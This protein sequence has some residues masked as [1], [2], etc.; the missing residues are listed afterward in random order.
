MGWNGFIPHVIITEFI[1]LVKIQRNSKM[2]K[3]PVKKIICEKSYR[4][5]L[6][7]IIYR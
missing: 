5:E 2:P 1:F 4:I 6:D 7:D 3:N